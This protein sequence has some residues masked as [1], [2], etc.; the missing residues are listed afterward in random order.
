MASLRSTNKYLVKKDADQVRDQIKVRV[1]DSSVF[2][3]L[4]LRKGHSLVALSNA[5]RKKVAKGA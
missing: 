2:E 5:S 1:Y 3:G 4:R